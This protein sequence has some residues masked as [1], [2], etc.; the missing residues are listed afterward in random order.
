[1][2]TKIMSVSPSGRIRKT[3]QGK[4]QASMDHRINDLLN[5]LGM[6]RKEYEMRAEFRLL[7]RKKLNNFLN[8]AR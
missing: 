8:L 6:S 2:V 4:T 3:I 1:M 5:E 7:D